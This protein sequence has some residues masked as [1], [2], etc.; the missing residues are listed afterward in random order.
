[1][2]L[3]NKTKKVTMV[4]VICLCF[5]LLS[6]P[7]MAQDFVG[8]EGSDSINGTSGNDTIQ[9]LGGGDYI[10]GFAG[11]D[12]ILGDNGDDYILGGDGND[13]L[14][15]GNEDDL[16]MGDAG[17]DTYFVDDTTRYGY[18]RIS[19][20]LQNASE[21]NRIILDYDLENVAFIRDPFNSN[22]L[23]IMFR[24][25]SNIVLVEGFF[26]LQYIKSVQCNDGTKTLQQIISM[27]S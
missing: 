19:E 2:M 21:N 9:G 3:K 12:T 26:D 22:N 23:I 18:D 24:Y 13:N 20:G 15:G 6:V 1:M 10:N 4:L 11:N 27:L 7:A 8:T 25:K 5:A 17:D 14:A 16:L